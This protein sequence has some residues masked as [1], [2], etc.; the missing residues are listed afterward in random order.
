MKVS[1]CM[2]TYNGASYIGEQ[3]SSILSQL[4]PDDEL[5]I[6]DDGSTDDTL[7]IINSFS[8]KRIK[9]FNHKKVKS[10]YSF[11]YTTRNF[12]NA[13]YNSTGD[14]IFLSDQDDV[15]LPNKY[16]VMTHALKEND[17][18]ISDCKIVDKDLNVICESKFKINP[19]SNRVIPC[20]KGNKN[21][22]CCMAF[23]RRIIEKV[24]PFPPYGVAQDWWLACYGNMYYKMS[25]INEPL[26]L[27]RRHEA[28][29]SATGGN[30][31][32]SIKD[33]VVI[34]LTFI[35]QLIKRGSII[36]IIKNL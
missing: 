12:E 7:E 24:L 18:V 10:K 14:I 21:I 11:D 3:I 29:V 16:M 34:R 2:A 19:P 8:D 33:K 20:L 30:S 32:Y 31:Q 35:F 25:Y 5:I 36:S 22:G 27:Y 13:I 28:T 26:M 23:N 9:L 1:V 6:S 4:N 15:W 17:I